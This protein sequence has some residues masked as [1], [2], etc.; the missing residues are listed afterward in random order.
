MQRSKEEQ[1]LL[2]HYQDMI[3]LSYQRGIPVY[4]QFAGLSEQGLAYQALDAF[5]GK[6]WQE[7]CQ[8]VLF[9]GYSEAER[10]LFCFLPDSGEFSEEQLDF[11]ISCVS[12]RPVNKRFCDALNHRD[13]L[14]TIMN[15]GVTR[16]QIGDIV[17]KQER[18]E[19]YQTST[20]Y[21]FC[22]RDKAELIAGLTRIKHTTVAP[23]IIPCGDL[24][25]TPE[26]K[27]HT[28]SVSSFRMDAVLSVAIGTSRS[29][30]ISLIQEGNVYLNGRCCTENAKR[31]EEGDV[32]SV[33]GYGKFIFERAGVQ[34]KKGRYHIIV[35]QY[36]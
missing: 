13:Y 4:T 33:R 23:E 11:P 20:G 22:K 30:G 6:S 25:W 36:I 31:L 26:F 5:Y 29:Q 34:T 2:Q 12:I 17:V 9:G 10:K 18:K 24:D 27:E 7:G 28:G 35:K 32:F 14:G 8:V 3:Q 16:D 19:A 15:L 1:I 21:I